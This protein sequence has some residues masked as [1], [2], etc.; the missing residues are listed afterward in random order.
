MGLISDM[1]VNRR[2]ARIRRA[3]EASLKPD[4]AYRDRRL[5]QFTPERRE[6]YHRN[7]MDL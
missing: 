3:L 6:R 4:P 2:K 7:V 5:A 1:I